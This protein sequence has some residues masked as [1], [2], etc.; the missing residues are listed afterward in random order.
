MKIILFVTLLSSAFGA[1]A[2]VWQ[3]SGTSLTE[4]AHRALHSSED[5]PASDLINN[6]LSSAKSVSSSPPLTAA[7]FLIAKGDNGSE[8]LSEL[9][10]SGKLPET[11]AK[12]ND[13]TDVY[14]HVSGL[15]STGFVVRETGKLINGKNRVLEV[16]LE[17]FKNKL[18]SL[19]GP[20]EVEIDSKGT[21]KASTSISSTNK[22][23]N[24][25]SRALSQADIYIVNVSPNEDSNKI[26]A[27]ITAAIDNKNVG[28][29][30][31]GGIRSVEEV[32]HERFLI[33]KRRMLKMEED[34][35]AIMESRR[36]NRRRLEQE[37][38]G[39]DAAQ[40]EG[41]D[42]MAG[43]YYV[44]MTPNILSGLLFFF[45]FIFVAYTGISCMGDIQGGDTFTDKYP[46]LGRES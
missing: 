23:V 25:R 44:A 45:M 35:N 16:S 27:S 1:P 24:K 34:G 9:A 22:S 46:S 15:E 21:P 18:S 42:D 11:Y 10:S 17:E 29:V 4:N 2:I 3:Q 12:Y 5:L 19:D 26:D 30:V 28:V 37:D 8:Q 32:K 7:F 41:N 38:A 14:H 43:V 36:R 31:L 40:A 33:N 6:V 13:A 39:D 20:V